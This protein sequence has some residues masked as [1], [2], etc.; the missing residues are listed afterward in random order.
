MDRFTGAIADAA[1][2]GVDLD[3]AVS[4]IDLNAQIGRIDVNDLLDRVD[5]DDL[6]DRVDVN[7]L[8][9][10]VDVD[11]LLDRVD[12]DRLLDRVDV[13]RLVDR[14]GIESI[15]ARSTGQ[16]AGGILDVVRRQVVAVDLI[17]LRVLYGLTGRSFADQPAG[18]DRL[19]ADMDDPVLRPSDVREADQVV[20]RYA[21]PLVRVLALALD[22]GLASALFTLG[23][24]LLGW[25]LSGVLGLQVSGGAGTGA[26][27]GAG[28]VV[29]FVAYWTATLSVGGRTPGMGVVGLR[30]LRA[31]GQPL[32]L[33]R[34]AVWTLVLPVSAV[35]GAGYV[36]ALVGGRRQTLHD[37]AAG[38][39]VVYDWGRHGADG[40]T[41]LARWIED[42]DEG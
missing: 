34:V 19:V 40:D 14:A 8:L 9:D 23:T 30:L 12:V 41:P 31:D 15:I 37:R 4:E 29:W 33:L 10:R 26:L 16:V 13:D 7:R 32:Q 17:V 22:V 11:R 3:G 42:H 20:G 28:L 36:L 24:A 39:C 25:V 6:L 5:V 18:P 21:G 1:V 2:R 38:A 35:F 27:F